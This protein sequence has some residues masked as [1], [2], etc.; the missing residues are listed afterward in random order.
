MTIPFSEMVR[1]WMGWCPNA[2]MAKTKRS[3]TTAQDFSVEHRYM[4][5]P[6]AS[7]TGRQ[8]MAYQGK[9][10]H[11]QRG[12]MIIGLFA[13]VI[14]FLLSVI[15]LEGFEWVVLIVLGIMCGVLLICSDLT[16]TVDERELRIRF[17]PAGL[18][19]KSWSLDEIES[20]TTVSNPW[21]YGI[22]IHWTPR[23][24]LYNVSGFQGVEVRLCSGTLFRIGTDEPE[25]LCRAIG[26]ACSEKNTLAELRG[27]HD[28]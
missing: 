20:V 25:V 21:Y 9:Y 5:S 1:E 15:I 13:A 8:G 10:E 7:G 23:G 19:R 17:G 24:V 6:R 26:P 18:I 27:Y 4:E 22:G 2:G 12:D 28:E 14:L 16:V 11:T 3:G